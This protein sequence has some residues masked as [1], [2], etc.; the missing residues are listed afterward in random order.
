MLLKCASLCATRD[1]W[2]FTW[3]DSSMECGVFDSTLNAKVYNVPAPLSLISYFRYTINGKR[4]VRSLVK[5][6]WN[7]V[8]TDCENLGGQLYYSGDVTKILLLHNVF[9]E[10]YL[11]IA[12]YR[13]PGEYIFR[14]INGQQITYSLPWLPTDPGMGT[15]YSVG[16]RLGGLADFSASSV[17]YGICEI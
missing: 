6:V 16:Y 3:D 11:W 7:N 2:L 5:D 17:S 15:Q 10:D 14:D 4:L 1:C 12:I 13:L 8:K 9:G